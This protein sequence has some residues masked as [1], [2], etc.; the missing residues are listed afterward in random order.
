MNTD[1][2]TGN[3]RKWNQGKVSSR[4]RWSQNTTSYM[5]IRIWARLQAKNSTFKCLRCFTDWMNAKSESR[6]LNLIVNLRM[7]YQYHTSRSTNIPKVPW[8][9]CIGTGLYDV[10]QCRWHI[11]RGVEVVVE[12][13]WL[14]YPRQPTDVQHPWE[15]SCRRKHLLTVEKSYANCCTVGCDVYDEVS[16]AKD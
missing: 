9:G 14:R 10:I 8:P 6:Y 4:S 13:H 16:N 7:L 5:C 12:S 2:V 1:A 15:T 11:R 3:T